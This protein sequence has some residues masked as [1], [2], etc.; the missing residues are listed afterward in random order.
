MENWAYHIRETNKFILESHPHY[1][2]KYGIHILPHQNFFPCRWE[3][4]IK[5]ETFDESTF[6]APRESTVSLDE[7]VATYGI[8]LFDTINRNHILNNK[9]LLKED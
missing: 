2:I 4:S 7:T 5:F 8:H 6:V 1:I 3:E 9:F